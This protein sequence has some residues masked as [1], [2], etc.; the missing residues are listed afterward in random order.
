MAG[1]IDKTNKVSLGD[2]FEDKVPY[3]TGFH[4]DVFKDVLTEDIDDLGEGI[5]HSK[6]K[7]TENEL[8]DS[9]VGSIVKQLADRAGGDDVLYTHAE[10]LSDPDEND[11]DGTVVIKLYRDNVTEEDSTGEAVCDCQE[12]ED[13]DTEQMDEVV[14]AAAIAGLGAIGTKLWQNREKVMPL[15]EKFKKSGKRIEALGDLKDILITP[16]IEK[17]ASAYTSYLKNE[18]AIKTNPEAVKKLLVKIAASQISKKF[19]ELEQGNQVADDP[20]DLKKTNDQ[21]IGDSELA[22]KEVDT[23]VAAPDESQREKQADAVKALVELGVG[24]NVAKRKVDRI[25]SADQNL[26]LEGIIKKA[27]QR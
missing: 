15:L 22:D 16:E 9:A 6:F 12:D 27:L 10:I 13:E 24:R 14:G 4:K 8:N 18:F 26:D 7:I 11:P 20:I 23:D 2:L 5:D 3:G 17:A 1:W 21:T 25:T 19:G